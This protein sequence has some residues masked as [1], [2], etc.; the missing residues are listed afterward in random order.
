MD[1]RGN[2]A[3]ASLKR[4]VERVEAFVLPFHFR[5]NSAPA[6]LKLLIVFGADGLA[7]EFPGQ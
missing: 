5:G 1:F 7:Y 2:S 4:G 6:S 3:P